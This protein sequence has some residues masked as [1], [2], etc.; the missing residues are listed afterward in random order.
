MATYV[1]N[2]NEF[3][4][5]LIIDVTKW[6]AGYRAFIECHYVLSQCTC[7]IRE[8]IFYLTCEIKITNYLA[9][10]QHSLN[11]IFRSVVLYNWP[12]S[13][14]SV[15]VRALADVFDLSSCI[16]SSQLMR[17]L[18]TKRITSTDTYRDMGTTVFS[19]MAYE[20]NT[21]RAMIVAPPRGSEGTSV[22]QGR[23]VWKYRPTRDSQIPQ[24]TIQ[25][26]H[27]DNKKNTICNKQTYICHTYIYIYMY[28]I[29]L[30]YRITLH[31][32]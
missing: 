8:Y 12:N 9:I 11:W 16:C 21:S 14:L 7:F 17:K 23:N 30:E 10:L 4:C 19:T 26:R 22:S 3:S 29:C 20:K 31:Y 25:K 5:I 27:M 2:F 28:I 15:V 6:L 18:C 24:A 1:C 13:S 32:Y